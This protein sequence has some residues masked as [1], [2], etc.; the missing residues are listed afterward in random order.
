MKIIY[1]KNSGMLNIIF[2]DEESVDSAE[3][4]PGVVVDYN[5]QNEIIGLELEDAHKFDLSKFSFETLEQK[6]S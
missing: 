4:E 6:I 1:D 3:I 5:A 2:R